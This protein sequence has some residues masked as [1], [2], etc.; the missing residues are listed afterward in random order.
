M[1]FLP[2]CC[3]PHDQEDEIHRFF[4]LEFEYLR[5]SKLKSIWR[6]DDNVAQLALILEHLAT[7]RALGLILSIILFAACPIGSLVENKQ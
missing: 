4:R 3:A 2:I 7:T 5:S 6:D 1:I